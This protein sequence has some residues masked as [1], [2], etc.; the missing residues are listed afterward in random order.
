MA[1]GTDSVEPTDAVLIIGGGLAG[2]A[3]AVGLAQHGS[4]S[5]ILESCPRLGGRA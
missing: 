5:T 3:A 2:L 1:V 4:G